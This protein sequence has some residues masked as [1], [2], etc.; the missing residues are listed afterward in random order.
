MS[1][2][3]HP[4]CPPH[5]RGL[6]SSHDQPVGRSAC[7]A[8][9][10]RSTDLGQWR[11]CRRPGCRMDRWPGPGR[12]AGADSLEVPLHRRRDDG[13]V[14][15]FDSNRN[16]AHGQPLNDPFDFECP[17]PPTEEELEAA[18]MSFPGPVRPPHSRLFRVR[19]RT[20]TRRRALHLPR[21][22]PAPRRGVGGVGARRGTGRRAW[23]C[24]GA[25]CLGGA[26][27]PQ[28]F[29]PVRAEAAGAAGAP[30]GLD[31]AAAAA[32]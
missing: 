19:D 1:R 32:R 16:Y 18:A 28:L 31:R 30:V 17:G 2:S 9:L 8:P 15:L 12:P 26:R 29:R 3:N 4:H 14:M 24:R 21:R 5:P 11:L 7:R 22:E 10:P 13:D 6:G 25:L 20:R 23:P 27:L